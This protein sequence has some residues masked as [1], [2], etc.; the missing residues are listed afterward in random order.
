[1]AK[2]TY[3]NIPRWIEVY[4][5]LQN[6]ADLLSEIRKNSKSKEERDFC[7]SL[8]SQLINVA[9]ALDMSTLETY[10]AY[11]KKQGAKNAL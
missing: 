10:H 6:V 7:G 2:F 8:T 9:I 3:E 4:K 5:H 1:M 11:K